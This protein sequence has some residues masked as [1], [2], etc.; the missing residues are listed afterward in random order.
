MRISGFLGSLHCIK[1]ARFRAAVVQGDKLPLPDPDALACPNIGGVLWH[2]Y[3]VP[4][5]VG[6]GKH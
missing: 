1:V 6:A 2:K 4:S 5:T 3:D